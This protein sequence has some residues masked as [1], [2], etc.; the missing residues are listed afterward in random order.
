M[1]DYNRSHSSY[2]CYEV[3]KIDC[4]IIIYHIY[5]RSAVIV[6]EYSTLS[7]HDTGH[8]RYPQQNTIQ[9]WKPICG[10]SDDKCLSCQPF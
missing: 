7:L 3:L 10:D 6:G 4:I 5:T 9:S 8:V 1:I 2:R